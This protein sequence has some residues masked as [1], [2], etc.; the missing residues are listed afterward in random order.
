MTTSPTQWMPAAPQQP[1]PA[2][3]G[4]ATAGFCLAVVGLLLGFVPVF[5]FLVTVPALLLSRAGRKAFLRGTA[6]TPGL[7]RSGTILAW[8]GTVICA[9]MTV[10]VI[11]GSGQAQPVQPAAAPAPPPAPVLISVPNVVGMSD[12]Q[13]RDTLRTAGF[14]NVV[15]GPSTGSQPGV[16][17]GTVT[18]QLPNVAALASAGDPI[19][20]GEAAAPPAPVVVPQAAPTTEAAP[21]TTQAARPFV[22]APDTHVDRPYVP[23][24]RA[25]SEPAAG[26][27]SAYYKNCAAARAAGAAPLH[28]GD[29]GYRA[30][31]DR[32][33]DGIAC[34]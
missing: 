34:E 26:G 3:N 6:P 29:P 19:T 4:R 18:T 32:D 14:T 21:P 2:A 9:V 23:A 31:L 30:G 13:A 28:T 7:S 33:G 17:A 5:G 12:L 15:L 10:V 20:L 11:A 24:P 22:A 1:D 27:G 25:A 8:I 16:A